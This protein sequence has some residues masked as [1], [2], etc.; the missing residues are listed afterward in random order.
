MCVLHIY[1][2]IMIARDQPTGWVESQVDKYTNCS[3]VQHRSDLGRQSSSPSVAPLPDRELPRANNY[4]LTAIF[5]FY[6]SLV[7]LF[8][9]CFVCSLSSYFGCWRLYVVL[10]VPSTMT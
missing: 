5:S 9:F 10:V 2:Y 3:P 7:V 1:V 8:C 4:L 6:F